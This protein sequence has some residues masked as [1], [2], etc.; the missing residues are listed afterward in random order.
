[1]VLTRGA[2]TD[3]G[4]GAYT[5]SA[6]LPNGDAKASYPAVTTASAGAGGTATSLATGTDLGFCGENRIS[7][8]PAYNI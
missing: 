7:V 5:Y 6:S 3:K 1:M 2:E 8:G 4:Y